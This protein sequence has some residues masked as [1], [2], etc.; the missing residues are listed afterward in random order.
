MNSTII[1]LIGFAG[2]GKLTIAKAIQARY[3]CI[4]VDNHFINNVILSLM[5]R[6][7]WRANSETGRHQYNV[8]CEI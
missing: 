5:R 2:C 4:L 3:D 7:A 8:F 1:Y 6:G